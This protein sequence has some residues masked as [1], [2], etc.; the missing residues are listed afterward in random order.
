MPDALGRAHG[1]LHSQRGRHEESVA[2]RGA[3]GAAARL[4]LPPG[5][6]QSKMRKLGI[7]R[8]EFT[9]R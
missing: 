8:G 1:H 3:D 6:L 5:T 7:A 9:R 4:G 2:R